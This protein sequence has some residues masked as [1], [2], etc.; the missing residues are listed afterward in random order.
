MFSVN[1]ATLEVS[2]FRSQSEASRV[3]GFYVS[4]INN[5]ITGK[6]SQTHG[7]WFAKYDEN[8][9]D[10][11]KRKLNEIKGVANGN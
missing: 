4:S 5:V 6:Q 9:D 2:R 3:L 1:L 10:I 7:Y 8:A 11:I